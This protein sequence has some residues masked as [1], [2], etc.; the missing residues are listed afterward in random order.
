[1]IL[2]HPTLASFVRRLGAL[3]LVPAVICGFASA[4]EKSEEAADKI[5]AISFDDVK[6]DLKKDQPYKEELLT[7]A[8]K[9]L[10]GKQV[11]IR[12][13]ILPSFQQTGIKQFVLVRDNMECCFGPGAALHD[14][15]VVEMAAGASTDYTVRPVTVEG[16]FS[17]KQL[18]D[19]E[20][21]TLAIY[22]LDGK[23]VK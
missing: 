23:S 12:G 19:P 13:Y 17:V 3:A 10:D 5:K 22:R 14:C 6:L 8:I 9:K 11:R 20:G 15:I 7:P 1:V 4:A 2:V 21:K 16:K 18:T